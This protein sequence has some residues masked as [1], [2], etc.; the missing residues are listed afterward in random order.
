MLRLLGRNPE[1]RPRVCVHVLSRLIRK[2]HS[3]S[4]YCEIPRTPP[5]LLLHCTRHRGLV[6]I[7]P[8]AFSLDL[9]HG[10]EAWLLLGCT[11]PV[12]ADPRGYLG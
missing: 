7:Q 10:F 3:S 9:G 6:P 2:P 5:F 12:A 1:H 11:I 8:C 4:S